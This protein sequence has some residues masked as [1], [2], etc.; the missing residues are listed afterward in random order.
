MSSMGPPT[1]PWPGLWEAHTILLKTGSTHEKL[2][3]D[4]GIT[5]PECIWNINEHGSEDMH[6]VKKVIGIKGIKEFQVQPREKPGRTTMLTYVN[7]AGFALPPMVIHRGKHLD[8]WRIDGPKRV[9]VKGSEKSYINKKLFCEYG[10][11]TIYMQQG[12]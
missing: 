11:I 8:S 5:D 10:K 6:K 2:I 9:L 4:L 3:E 12:K 1:Y 7:A